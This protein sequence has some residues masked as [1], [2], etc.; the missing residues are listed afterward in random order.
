MKKILL[1]LILLILSGCIDNIR[2]FK[3]KYYYSDGFSNETI[4]FDDSTHFHYFS[5]SDDGSKTIGKGIYKILSDTLQL[6][7]EINE[8][9]RPFCY[10]K[11]DSTPSN[12]DQITLDI[13]FKN[14]YTQKAISFGILSIFSSDGVK[15]KTDTCDSNGHIYI[16][17]NKSNEELE[18]NTSFMQK[19]QHY[20]YYKTSFHLK[21]NKNYNISIYSV[22]HGGGN[23]YDSETINFKLKYISEK[24]IE[25]EDFIN[26]GRIKKF[27]HKNTTGN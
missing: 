5:I 12:D 9:E 11:I 6:K 2:Y 7:F 21:L 18:F 8:N 17:L 26:N 4:T 23:Y 14:S 20:L 16:K 15:I 10:N 19:P 25:L 22:S 1:I 3:G 24:R 13:N 27:I